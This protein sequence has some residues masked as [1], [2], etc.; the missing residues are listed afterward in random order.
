MQFVCD[1]D[2]FRMEFVGKVAGEKTGE[3]QSAA[4]ISVRGII[5]SVR[6]VG[7]A[8]KATR[9]GAGKIGEGEAIVAGVRVV[10]EDELERVQGSRD[11][12]S[13]RGAGVSGI[14]MGGGCHD[15]LATLDGSP[16]AH[17]VAIVAAERGHSLPPFRRIAGWRVSHGYAGVNTG[18]SPDARTKRFM[19][20]IAKLAAHSELVR[21]VVFGLRPISYSGCVLLGACRN[22]ADN[23]CNGKTVSDHGIFLRSL[24]KKASN[25]CTGNSKRTP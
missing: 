18:Y 22:S 1:A 24:G 6:Q 8:D 17:K 15:K 3:S 11:Q 20:E 5:V 25:Y 21:L 14:F 2:D 10:D 7:V 4:R 9:E 12:A 23:K 16:T 19:H 13:A